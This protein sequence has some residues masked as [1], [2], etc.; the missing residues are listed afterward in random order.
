MRSLYISILFLLVFAGCQQEQDNYTG[1]SITYPLFQSSEFA[2]EGSAVVRELR[3]GDLELVLTLTGPK[4]NE[5]Y[6]FPS[7]LHFGNYQ[8]ANSA[9]AS[10]L[11]PIDIRTLESR[12]LLGQLSDGNRVSFEDF[13]NFDGH[14]KIHLADEGPDYTTILVAG[15]VGSNP[16]SA[17][18][19]RREKV[20]ICTPYYP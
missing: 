12:T 20:A 2:Y 13:R 14:I 1:N 3:T 15:N 10:M 18:Q 17:E 11:N 6:F 16:A 19:F 4:A 5:A 8:E 9:I 7:H